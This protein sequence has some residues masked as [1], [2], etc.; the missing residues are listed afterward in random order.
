MR[1]AWIRR[2]ALN[3]FLA[4]GSI[5][6]AYLLIELIFFHLFLPYVPL[7]VVTHLPDIVGVLVQNT[8]AQF[9]PHDYIALMGD[10]Y[11]EG[12]GDWLLQAQGD[13]NKPYYSGNVIHDTTGRD[14]VTFGRAGAGS[15]QAMVLRP[16]RIMAG[17]SC[18]LF[19]T[20]E[21]PKDIFIYFYEGNDVYDNLGFLDEVRTS[22][23][24]ADDASVDRHLLEE[25]VPMSRWKCHSYLGDTAV[26]M[27]TFL[28]QHYVRG[29]T[30]DPFRL[31][32]NTL[33]VAG[34]NVPAPPL[35]GPGLGGPEDQI[36]ASM[37]VFDR[38]LAWLRERFPGVPT[39]IVYLPSPASVYRFAGDS[40]R[41]APARQP[42][43]EVPLSLVASRSDLICGLLQKAA[44]ARGAGFL[45]TRQALRSL[46]ATKVIHGP[47]DWFHYNEAG[48]R[49]LGELVMERLNG[50]RPADS[51]DA[52]TDWQ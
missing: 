46:A 29:I 16:A 15:A 34:Q 18:Y 12:V 24:N 38:S 33:V 23:G 47:L 48:Y 2:V 36:R 41:W 42:G 25:Y 19:P 30:F 9:V 50:R 35:Q 27:A 20:L 43:M 1:Q 39:T 31:R 40:V 28:Y 8:K 45:D 3:A 13:R 21:A 4:T 37:R 14:L 51:C 5:A 17:S 6:V 52:I 11:A 49:R 22:Y 32:E 44:T 10:S 26:R 7:N